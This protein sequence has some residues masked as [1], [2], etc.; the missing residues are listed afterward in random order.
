MI[1]IVGLGNPGK[2]FE[3]TR[4]NAGFMALDELAR[5]LHVDISQGKHN[6]LL[7]KA[8]IDAEATVLA[9]PQTYMNDSGRAVGAILTD[10]YAGISNLIVLH[11]ELDLPFGTVR[12]K[13]GGGH[14]GHNGLRS[15][16]E[17]VGSSDFMRVRLGIGRPVPGMDA[18]DYVLSPFLA[19]ERQLLPDVLARAVEA[20]KIIVLEGPNKAMNIFN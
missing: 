12:I 7:G 8:R 15:I 2:K 13:I 5:S 14:G 11:D 19:E 18:A 16:I 4:H 1:I 10:T 17:Q 6:A 3:R 20:V 9:K